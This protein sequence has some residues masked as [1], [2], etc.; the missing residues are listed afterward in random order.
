MAA[1]PESKQK[2]FQETE[3]LA[4]DRQL[5]ECLAGWQ[6]VAQANPENVEAARTVARLAIELDRRRAGLRPRPIGASCLDYQAREGEKDASGH[7]ADTRAPEGQ[8]GAAPRSIPGLKLTP[9]QQLEVAIRDQPSHAESY[10]RLVPLY[11]EKERDYDAE[12]LLEKG[13]E[14]TG[15]A[16]VRQL[17]ENVVLLRLEKKIDFARQEAERN[18]TPQSRA[19]LTQMRGERDRFA[20]EVFTSR[21]QREPDNLALRYELGLRLQRA[22]KL[23]AASEQFQEALADAATKSAAAFQ[24]GQCRAQFFEY[25]QALEYYRLAADSAAG[26]D[27]LAGKQEALY[28]AAELAA[29]VKLKSTARRYLEEL[30]ELDPNYRDAAGLLESMPQVVV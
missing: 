16:R 7:S 2:R 12:R 14:A 22:G 21:C 8:A 25:P 15:D 29:R 20:I 5:E 18:D 10:L 28:R 4:T 17:W 1:V 24:L 9:I 13:K 6:Q 23:R 19:E 3:G 30:L 27:Q 11:L 26:P